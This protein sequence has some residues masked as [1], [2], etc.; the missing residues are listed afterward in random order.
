MRVHI[1]PCGPLEPHC[2]T[3]N[4]LP[5]APMRSGG[6]A[7]LHPV[8]GATVAPFRNFS[9]PW[10]LVLGFGIL[11]D[12]PGWWIAAGTLLVVGWGHAMLQLERRKQWRD[13][14]PQPAPVPDRPLPKG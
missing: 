7:P 14:A 12:I 9:L 2:L 4:G 3:G 13:P 11:R 10:G 5:V 8:Q 6:R 1:G